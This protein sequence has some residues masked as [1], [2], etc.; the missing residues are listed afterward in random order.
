MRQFMADAAHELRTPLAVVRSRAEVAPAAPAKRRGVSR[1]RCAASSARANDSGSIVDDLLTL[2]RA[3]AGERPV[4]RR[5]VF[6]DD[7]TLDAAEAVRVIADR[8]SVRLEVDD[9]EEAAVE[10]DP[11]LLRQL[12]VILLDNA[13]KFTPAG[14]FVRI[15]VRSTPTSAELTVSDTGIGIEPDKLPLRVRSVLPRA[16]HRGPEPRRT[17]RDVGRGR[18]GARDRPLDR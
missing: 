15:G 11:N 1:R 8:K 3:D 9:F 5:R 18:A 12:V 17:L 7:V 2:A 16:I 4:E 10:G 14:G 13:I 6:F